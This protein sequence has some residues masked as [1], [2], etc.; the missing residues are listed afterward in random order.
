MEIA[1]SQ[2]K[3]LMQMTSLLAHLPCTLLPLVAL[4]FVS[5]CSTGNRPHTALTDEQMKAVLKDLYIAE[6]GVKAQ[7]RELPQA[8]RDSL[9]RQYMLQALAHHNVDETEFRQ[10]YATY[11]DYPAYLKT[12][13]E[14]IA[15]ELK[16][17][18]EL[19]V[20]Q[21]PP[22]PTDTASTAPPDAVRAGLPD[23]IRRRLR[24]PLPHR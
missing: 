9:V 23:S 6:Y 5:A 21:H 17:E 18:A 20:R 24:L 8:A 4:L 12:L 7:Y 22:V 16:A 1:K 10:A 2:N 15:A 14:E 13:E 11:Q 3:R 19:A